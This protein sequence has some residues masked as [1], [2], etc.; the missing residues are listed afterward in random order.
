MSKLVLIGAA[1]PA[2]VK[3]PYTPGGA[4][5]QVVDQAAPFEDTAAL[6]MKPL[7]QGE[8]AHDRGWRI[9]MRPTP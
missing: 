9:E 3:T 2:M 5:I 8:L 6:L 1:P 7:M 4:P